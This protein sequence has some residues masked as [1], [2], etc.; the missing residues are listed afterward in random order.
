MLAGLFLPQVR[1][2]FDVLGAK[3]I[4]AEELGFD[5]VWFMDHLAAPADPT[6]DV[7]EAW[8]TIAAVAARTSRVRLGHLVGCD[9]IRHPAVVAK[10]AVT[11]DHVSGGR[12]DLGLGWGSVPDELRAFGFGSEPPARRAGRLGE[13]LEVLDALFTGEP[14]TYAG[15]YHQLEGAVCRPLPTQA[16]IPIHLGGAGPKLTMPL[17]ARFADWWNCPCY[18]VDRLPLLRATAGRARVSVQHPIGLAPSRAAVDEVRAV[19]ERRFGSW[20]GLLVGTPDDIIAALGREAALGVEQAIIQFHD[21]ASRR[22][23]SC[24]PP[25]SSPPSTA[26]GPTHAQWRWLR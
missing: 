24:S 9:P 25:R 7:F 17:V 13:T 26:E 11:V 1:M 6:L 4:A 2:P 16:R 23:W 21:F 18:A 22:R 8:T 12:L 3:A 19:A 15:Q 5:S 14:V 10:M 20:G